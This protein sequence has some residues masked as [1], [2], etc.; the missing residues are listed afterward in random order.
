MSAKNNTTQNN[1][2][3]KT[4]GLLITIDDDIEK[5]MHKTANY[6]ATCILR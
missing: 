6:S 5:M 3:I 4:K 2:P 1:T